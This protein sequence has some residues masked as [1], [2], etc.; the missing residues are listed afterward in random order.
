MDNKNV[1]TIPFYAHEGEMARLERINRRLCIAV[2]ALAVS[3][4][5]ICTRK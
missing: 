3:S 2:V 4:V 5:I 1:T